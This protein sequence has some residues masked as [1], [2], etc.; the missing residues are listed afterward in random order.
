MVEVE[1]EWFVSTFQANI[2]TFKNG[3]ILSVKDGVVQIIS[4]PWTD[5]TMCVFT[6]ANR[7]DP[8]LSIQI[9]IPID[10]CKFIYNC[11]SK[12]TLLIDLDGSTLRCIVNHPIFA[13]EYTVSNTSSSTKSYSIPA[14][15]EDV[16]ATF[17][18]S[19]WK[20]IVKTMP[21]KGTCK[22][23]GRVGKKQFSLVNGDWN[24]IAKSVRA[25]YCVSGTQKNVS[26]ILSARELKN[27]IV[28]LADS[29]EIDIIWTQNGVFKMVANNVT[30]YIAPN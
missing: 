22:M 23:S 10:L 16:I 28:F 8:V 5:A 17:S 1:R 19:S 4:I 9:R 20:S 29:W 24:T 18:T 21:D 11:P 13:L 6:S 2:H 27:I 26:V 14:S 30:I 15:T 7:V 25:L 3:P 12:S